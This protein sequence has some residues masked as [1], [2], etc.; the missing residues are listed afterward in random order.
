MAD[1][2]SD[3]VADLD[4]MT[5]RNINNRITVSFENSGGMLIGKIKL[6]PLKLMQNWM[7]FPNSNKLIEKAVLEA[8]NVFLKAYRDN[9]GEGSGIE[10]SAV[11]CTA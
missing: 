6:I 11:R 1:T 5:C 7:R 8:E 10:Q 4:D 2:Y 3:W 9:Q